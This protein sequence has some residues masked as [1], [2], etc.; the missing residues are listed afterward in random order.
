MID[1]GKMK[2]KSALEQ[3]LKTPKEVKESKKSFRWSQ[4]VRFDI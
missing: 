2:M 1:S 4:I 3:N